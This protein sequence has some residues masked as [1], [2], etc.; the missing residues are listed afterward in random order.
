VQGR[1]RE[2][3]GGSRNGALGHNRRASG[4]LSILAVRAL[5]RLKLAPR[6]EL[7]LQ[8]DAVAASQ[9]T[10]SFNVEFLKICSERQEDIN[11]F[12]LR[13]PP[14]TISRPRS[15]SALLPPLFSEQVPLPGPLHPRGNERVTRT[16]LGMVNSTVA[17]ATRL[18]IPPYQRPPLQA[19]AQRPA[20]AEAE[21]AGG[22]DY[23]RLI[24]HLTID[25][26]IIA[27]L[28]CEQEPP[29]TLKEVIRLKIQ[30]ASGIIMGVRRLALKAARRP[31]A[32]VLLATAQ[33]RAKGTYTRQTLLGIAAAAKPFR[34]RFL[35]PVQQA[36]EEATKARNSSILA[37][38]TAAKE[39]FQE[40]RARE[41]RERMAAL[42]SNDLEAY[43]RLASK[44]KNDA[45]QRL[46]SQTDACLRKLSS[47]LG[48]GCR[49]RQP[50]KGSATR[51]EGGSKDGGNLAP[52]RESS[53]Q[54]NRLAAA[55]TS[56]VV[57]QPAA[58]TGAE[59]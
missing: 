34:E 20:P 8:G 26:G 11:R 3:L 53:N 19:A 58:L 18:G 49:G 54:W 45:I 22:K 30:R 13:Q 33:A 2:T 55:F 6:D 59:G 48:E 36:K 56:N 14:R 23:V 32:S 52:L 17:C 7:Q 39:Q 46:L 37:V 29:K 50:A 41:Q 12:V 40:A 5:K 1:E 9:D 44:S 4:D 31:P 47:R 51:L 57:E 21:S 10:I 35:L 38:H 43:L 28:F 15:P 42:K 16:N 27:R 24:L 25:G